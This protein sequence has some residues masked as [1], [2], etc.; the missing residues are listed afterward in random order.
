MQG[1]AQGSVQR[2]GVVRNGSRDGEKVKLLMVSDSDG[3]AIARYSGE[4]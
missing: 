4:K 2:E 1:S 3:G